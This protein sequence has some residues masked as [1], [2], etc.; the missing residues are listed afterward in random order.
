MLLDR[1]TNEGLD[2]DMTGYLDYLQT[3]VL[4]LIDKHK[5]KLIDKHENKR[6]DQNKGK[7]IDK[8]ENKRFDNK[9]F[10]HDRVHGQ[11]RTSKVSSSAPPVPPPCRPHTAPTPPPHR[12]HTAPARHGRPYAAA[13]PPPR[14]SDAAP[15]Q[16]QH[17][18]HAAQTPRHATLTPPQR[19]PGTPLPRRPHAAATPPPHPC[20]PLAPQPHAAPAPLHAALTPPTPPPQGGSVLLYGWGLG[21][22]GRLS[23]GDF[24]SPCTSIQAL[25]W[26]MTLLLLLGFVYP[27][28]SSCRGCGAALGR[29]L[30][31]HRGSDRRFFV[32]SR[33]WQQPGWGGGPGGAAWGW[34]G[35]LRGAR[36]GGGSGGGP[37]R[38]R[39]V[40][41]MAGQAEDGPARLGW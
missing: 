4:V 31:G 32:A 10:A 28:I 35:G 8:H 26:F 15:T 13:A 39:C 30:W 41:G 37:G 38:A 12:P 19:R 5:G 6:I 18:P 33:A 17:R 34:G 11:D 2:K 29:R 23:A 24:G 22:G 21:L 7:R 14:R 40:A 3:S 36:W 16:Q 9:R 20:T 25:K 1:D 27:M